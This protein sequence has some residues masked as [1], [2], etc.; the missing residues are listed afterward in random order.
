[1]YSPYPY[2]NSQQII[3]VT[4]E[5]GAN[6]FQLLPNSSVLLLD[7]SAPRVFLVTTDGAGYKSISA[8]KLEPYEAEPEVDLTLLVKRIEKLERSING[9]S[10]SSN[11]KQKTESE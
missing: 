11:A 2:Q 6:A 1:M 9:K 3:K 5:Q 10:N 4:G 7:S 8:Y